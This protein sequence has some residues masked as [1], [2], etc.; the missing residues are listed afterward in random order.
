MHQRPPIIVWFRQDLRLFDNPALAEASKV[1]PILPIYILDDV[2]AG[3]FKMGGAS[4]VW[5]Y[6]SLKALNESC[7]GNLCL[8][9]GD[10]LTVL[11]EIIQK[12]G[13][14]GVYWNRCYE[15]WR[16]KR[17]Q[18][19]KAYLTSSQID[20]KS[21]NGSLLWEPWEVLKQDKTPYR[22]FT[23]FFKKGCLETSSPRLP[24]NQQQNI[25][26]VKGTASHLLDELSLLPKISWHQS[27]QAHW[28]PGEVGAHIR[29]NEFLEKGIRGYQEGRNFP[30]QP[31]ISKLSPHLRFGEISPNTVW[32]AVQNMDIPQYDKDHFLSE[33]G[34]REFSYHLLYHN[35]SMPVENLQ[36]KFDAFPWQYDEEVL[37]RWQQGKT[38]YPIVDAGMRELWQTGYM[39][40]RVRMIVAS[41]LVKNL[42]IHWRHGAQWFW[43]CLV[44][45]DLANNSASWQWVAGCGADA[46]PFFRIFNPVTQAEKFDP[47]GNYIKKFVPELKDMPISYVYAPWKAPKDVLIRL[48]MKLSENYFSPM[49]NLE[50]SR[51]LA[52]LN[53]NLIKI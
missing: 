8:Y 15:P 18:H 9:Q 20:C 28:Q 52:L 24:I 33:L 29:L 44:D 23:P 31:H 42:M 21:F 5:L 22:V 17:D 7:Q 32:Y 13:A 11:Q 2:N 37:Q 26:W 14:T 38:G 50:E 43:D 47:E 12:T 53:L 46:A 10:P 34:W 51:N 27:L 16:I 45:A 36:K 4:R 30:S 6:H 1:A 25:T 39:H 40:N 41:F 19:I 3:E 49:V 35:P 48:N